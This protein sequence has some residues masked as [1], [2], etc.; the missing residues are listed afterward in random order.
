MFY[1]N[2]LFQKFNFQSIRVSNPLLL[3][4]NGKPLP[5]SKMSS[6]QMSTFSEADNKI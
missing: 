3:A 6:M 5:S 2:I 1:V 4:V